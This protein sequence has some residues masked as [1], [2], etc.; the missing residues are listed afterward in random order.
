[1]AI[2]TLAQVLAAGNSAL[3]KITNLTNGT[4][5]QDAA[6]FGQ[7]PVVARPSGP[8]AYGAAAVVGTGAAF[9]RNDH[10]HGLPA[11]PA[12][13]AAATTVTGPDAYGAA[14]AVGTGTAYARNDHDHGLPAAPAASL[15]NASGVNGGTTSLPASTITTVITTAS[16]T[17]GTWLIDFTLSAQNNGST[18]GVLQSYIAV[19]TATA[20][21]SPSA[22]GPLTE[23][24]A[25]TG[26]YAAVSQTCIATITVAG[27]I[28]LQASTGGAAATNARSTYTAVKI[29]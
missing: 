20:T 2:P 13:P 10:D 9:A 11:A 26:G 27:T 6:A 23:L 17:I 12:V 3:A 19:G 15:A 24:P 28:L 7:I 8:D 29:A 18:A 25:L 4:A 5:A 16:L 14:A 1:M 21:L 22:P